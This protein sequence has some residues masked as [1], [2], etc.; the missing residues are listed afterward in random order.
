MTDSYHQQTEGNEHKRASCLGE[1]RPSERR[2]LYRHDSPRARA[3]VEKSHESGAW[4]S[5]AVEID[6]RE[7]AEASMARIDAMICTGRDQPTSAPNYRRAREFLVYKSLSNGLPIPQ[8][9]LRR[10]NPASVPDGHGHSCRRY[11]LRARADAL[12][13]GRQGRASRWPRAGAGVAPPVNAVVGAL[14]AA[15]GRSTGFARQCA[16]DEVGRY[17]FW[18]ARRGRP[19][20]RHANLTDDGCSRL[21]SPARLRCPR[22]R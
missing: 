11:R 15:G 9:L 2:K 16:A 12:L 17:A 21:A 22:A 19:G 13:T 8:H 3:R 5:A 7:S 10:Q 6:A 20:R 1:R 18:R 4:R 14:S